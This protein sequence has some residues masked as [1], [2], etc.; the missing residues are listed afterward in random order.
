MSAAFC[1]LSPVTA[2]PAPGPPAP[3]TC[4][5]PTYHIPPTTYRL[6]HKPYRGWNSIASEDDVSLD[7][8]SRNPIV[9]YWKS[10]RQERLSRERHTDEHC[11]IH[12]FG[13]VASPKWNEIRCHLARRFVQRSSLRTPVGSSLCS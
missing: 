5:S 10:E 4:S 6:I 9:V 13:V 3:G 2:L 7:R 8:V 1:L 12:A 11:L